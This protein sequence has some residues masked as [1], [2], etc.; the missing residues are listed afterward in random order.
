MPAFPALVEPAP[1]PGLDGPESMPTLPTLDLSVSRLGTTYFSCKYLQT[2]VKSMDCSP[3]A[4]IRVPNPL[5][6]KP[7]GDQP[8]KRSERY[9]GERGDRDALPPK[10]GKSLKRFTRGVSMHRD[11]GDAEGLLEGY[12]EPPFPLQ[13][14]LKGRSNIAEQHSGPAVSCWGT[15]HETSHS[16]TPYKL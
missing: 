10:R 9:C 3:L 4:I 16:R 11:E 15:T 1:L 13:L 7:C 8:R 6:S 14:A 12:F 2:T 5:P